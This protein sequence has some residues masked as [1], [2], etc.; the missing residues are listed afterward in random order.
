MIGVG[1][2]SISCLFLYKNRSKLL[3]I[4]AFLILVFYAGFRDLSV[5]TDTINY[6]NHFNLVSSGVVLPHE[7]LWFI[8]NKSVYMFGGT[9]QTVLVVSSVLTLFPVFYVSYKKSPYPLLSIFFYISLYYYFYSFNIIRQCIAMSFGLMAFH[10]IDERKNISAY[11]IFFISVLFHYSALIILPGLLFISTKHSINKY[12]SYV[13]LLFSCVVGLLFGGEL[14]NLMQKFLYSDYMVDREFNLLGTSVLLLLLNTLYITMSIVTKKNNQW[15]TLFFLFILLSNLTVRIPL[16]NRF[17][18]YYGLTLIIFF[19]LLLNNNRLKSNGRMPLFLG[20]IVYSL[21]IL[22]TS[23]GKG[24]ILPY[25][26][27]L[28]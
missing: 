23:W 19:P 26:N 14:L 15:F 12:L 13:I 3:L 11:I 28:F 1:L 8:V 24:E 4:A 20:L 7:L 22:F 9:F 27:A 17:V 21:I 6:S 25:I 16:A 5:G 10:F 18:F 2:V